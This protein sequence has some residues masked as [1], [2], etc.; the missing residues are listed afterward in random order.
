M[1]EWCNIGDDY[2]GVMPTGF[3]AMPFIVSTG[4]TLIDVDGPNKQIINNMKDANVQRCQEFLSDIANQG[5]VNA[6]YTDPSTCLSATKTL[7]AEFGLDWGWTS[8]QAAAK[9]QDIRFVP[10]PRDDKADKYYTNTDTFGY[11]VPAGQRT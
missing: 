1:T 8:A 9:D 7:F 6:E 3:V 4:T 11:L 2:Y 10:I 5:M